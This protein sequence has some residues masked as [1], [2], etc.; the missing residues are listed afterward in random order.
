MVAGRPE[1]MA[2]LRVKAGPHGWVPR[3]LNLIQCFGS[4]GN[5]RLAAASRQRAF[6]TGSRRRYA[7]DSD[8]RDQRI[9][10]LYHCFDLRPPTLDWRCRPAQPVSQPE[11]AGGIALDSGPRDQKNSHPLSLFRLPPPT[12]GW[13]CRPSQ[14]FSQPETVVSV[15]W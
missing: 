9:L 11:A 8:P 3:K 10:T 13:R 1:L 2:A 14:P 12:L 4:N 15:A 5:V 6:S 7:R